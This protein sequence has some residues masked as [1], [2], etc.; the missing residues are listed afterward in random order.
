LAA[1]SRL[2]DLQAR[3]H[4]EDALILLAKLDQ[5][6]ESD[7]TYPVVTMSEGHV[8]ALRKLDG[9]T[10]ARVKAKE[11]VDLLEKRLRKGNNRRLESARLMLFTY[12]ATGRWKDEA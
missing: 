2:P 4:L 11:Y 3:A 1:S 9:D 7:D 6:L 8:Q 10:V 12:A 5:T